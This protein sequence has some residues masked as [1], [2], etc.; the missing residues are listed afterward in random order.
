MLLKTGKTSLDVEGNI[1]MLS[2]HAPSLS[3]ALKVFQK[4]KCLIVG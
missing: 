1:K 3:Q 4:G 2:A